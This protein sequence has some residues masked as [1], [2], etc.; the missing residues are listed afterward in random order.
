MSNNSGTLFASSV[1]FFLIRRTHFPRFPLCRHRPNTSDYDGSTS[2]P[3]P[4]GDGLL[5]PGDYQSVSTN[6]TNSHPT[7]DDDDTTLSSAGGGGGAGPTAGGGGGVPLGSQGPRHSFLAAT[8]SFLNAQKPNPLSHPNSSSNAMTQQ[9]PPLT[10][11]PSHLS[12]TGGA[13]AGAGASGAKG[14]KVTIPPG[15]MLVKITYLE[16]L[17][18]PPLTRSSF[19]TL[20]SLC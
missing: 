7:A 20:P 17:V 14:G 19:M 6:Q 3:P 4:K 15:K 2:H 13:G 9:P 8:F 18:R 11:A 16:E 12:T 5:D 10:S 1:R